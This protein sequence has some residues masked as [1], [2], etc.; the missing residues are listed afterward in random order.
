MLNVAPPV[1][2]TSV[3][4]NPRIMDRPQNLWV[5][6]SIQLSQHRQITWILNENANIESH[7]L[8]GDGFFRHELLRP[9]GFTKAVSARNDSPKLPAPLA[10]YRP[11]YPSQVASPHC[12]SPFFPAFSVYRMAPSVAKIIGRRSPFLRK[13]RSLDSPQAELS[14]PTRG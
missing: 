11:R 4:V 2:P 3:K 12:L 1:T 5:R 13:S 7:Y 10:R 14:R 9:I 8:F 6:T